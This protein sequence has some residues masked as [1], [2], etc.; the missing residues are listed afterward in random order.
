VWSSSPYDPIGWP[1]FITWAEVVNPSLY[2]KVTEL[3]NVASRPLLAV[4][5]TS[6]D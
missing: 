5:T 2:D 6:D 3:T 4:S 1:L